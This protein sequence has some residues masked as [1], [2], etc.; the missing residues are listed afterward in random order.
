MTYEF[1]CKPNIYIFHFFFFSFLEIVQSEL[2][3]GLFK[4]P[5]NIH[6]VKL[7]NRHA[8]TSMMVECIQH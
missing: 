4:Y 3:V 2:Y 5:A 6:L 8:R 7:N 1:I